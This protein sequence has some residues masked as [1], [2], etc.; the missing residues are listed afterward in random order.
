LNKKK[1]NI[2][3]FAWGDHVMGMGHIYRQLRLFEGINDKEADLTFYTFANPHVEKLL[4]GKVSYRLIESFHDINHPTA[5]THFIFDCLDVSLADASYIRNIAKK[6]F[7]F[8][9]NGKGLKYCDIS[10]NCLYPNSQK[11]VLTDLKYLILRK[12][13]LKYR[14]K[15]KS[16][17]TKRVLVMQGGT[18]TY[19][20][21]IRLANLLP[22]SFLDL[23]FDF[24][25]GS[26]SLYRNQIEMVSE[27]YKNMKLYVDVKEFQKM[28]SN[29]DTAIT[30]G[31]MS[32][33]EIAA[34]GVPVIAGTQELKELK[35]IRQAKDEGVILENIGLFSTLTDFQI[36]KKFENNIKNHKKINEIASCAMKKLDCK[37]I[38]RIIE[39][40]LERNG[41]DF[42]NCQD[43]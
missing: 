31:G 23:E 2:G 4:K 3:V 33:F 9:N 42:E 37:G 15:E 20:V 30:G 35:T 12:D 11:N 32:M 24:V 19:G 5:F 26:A 34:L 28:A 8:D 18:D 14:K 39:K 25:V 29:Y 16:T 41:G 7:S 6:I 21:L 1:A 17:K 13:G 22:S 43:C 27:K 40:I 36:K 10:F 38:D